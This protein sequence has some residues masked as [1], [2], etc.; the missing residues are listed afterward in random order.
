MLQS[1]N[2]SEAQLYVVQ[3]ISVD[4]S[5]QGADLKVSLAGWLIGRSNL[6]L[7]TDERVNSRG[8][9][10]AL[11]QS[12]DP[13][14]SFPFPIKASPISITSYIIAL[15]Q[16][17]LSPAASPDC[18]AISF[19]P[20]SIQP[21]T[22][23]KSWENHIILSVWSHNCIRSAN[24]QLW[25]CFRREEEGESSTSQLVMTNRCL[26]SFPKCYSH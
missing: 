14:V 6:R 1:I 11:L 18:D 19:G 20:L 12:L 26:W 15:V 23:N 7:V 13:S 16:W 21:Q 22:Q 3:K 10:W 8:S 9:L 25:F 17:L 5:C 2:Q 24:T 4:K